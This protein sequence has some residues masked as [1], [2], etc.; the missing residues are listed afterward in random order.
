MTISECCEGIVCGNTAFI[1]AFGILRKLVWSGPNIQEGR[2]E[3][4]LWSSASSQSALWCMRRG[5]VYLMLFVSGPLHSFL[6]P[7]LSES[8]KLPVLNSVTQITL[9]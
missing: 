5:A 2:R 6:S 4:G 7:T 8:V 9:V 3:L 1:F